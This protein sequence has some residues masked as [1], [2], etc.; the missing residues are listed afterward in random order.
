MEVFDGAVRIRRR[1]CCSSSSWFPILQWDVFVVVSSVSRIPVSDVPRRP[2]LAWDFP[3]SNSSLV[4]RDETRTLPKEGEESFCGW[5]WVNLSCCCS[6]SSM[7]RETWGV[8]VNSLWNSNRR[9]ILDDVVPNHCREGHLYHHPHDD[10]VDRPC[11]RP[12]P[13]IVEERQ[14]VSKRSSF[15]ATPFDGDFDTW[16][17]LSVSLRPSSSY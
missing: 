2:I 1:D 17:S 5:W 3:W 9:G 8:G 4:E 14:W 7:R 16:C 10:V 6:C 13:P 11:P 15:W 12:P